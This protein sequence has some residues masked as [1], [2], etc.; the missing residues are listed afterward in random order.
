M[1]KLVTL[2]LALCMVLCCAAAAAETTLDKNITTGTTEIT[3]VIDRSV[4]TYEVVIPS[5]VTIDPVTKKGNATVT[6]KAGCELISCNRL[7][8]E[9]TKSANGAN[10]GGA[11]NFGYKLKSTTTDDYCQYFIYPSTTST[12]SINLPYTAITSV[13]STPAAPTTEDQTK[14][15]TFKARDLPTAGIYTDTLT[16]SIII[17]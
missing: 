9:L 13:R 11:S 4:D 15:F 12:D 8:V 10:S 2:V 3:M 17:E 7:I 16:F 1:K 5:A 14:T 6:L